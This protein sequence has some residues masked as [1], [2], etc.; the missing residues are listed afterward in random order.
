MRRGSDSR[1]RMVGGSVTWSSRALLAAS[2]TSFQSSP[3]SA[4]FAGR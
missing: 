1:G 4:A 2:T 3:R